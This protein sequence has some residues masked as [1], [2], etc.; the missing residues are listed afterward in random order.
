MIVAQLRE[1]PAGCDWMIERWKELDWALDLKG[2]WNDECRAAAFDLLGAPRGMREF[3][4]VLPAD[5]TVNEKRAIARGKIDDLTKY[6]VEVLDD[7]DLKD[8]ERA[9]EG[10]VWDDSPEARR[11][12][13]YDERNSRLFHK[14]LNHF[15]KRLTSPGNM[16]AEDDDDDDE[17]ERVRERKEASGHVGPAQ[18]FKVLIPAGLLP[19]ANGVF[20][21]VDPAL[22]GLSAEEL[23]EKIAPGTGTPALVD[24]IRRLMA[25][26]RQSA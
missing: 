15:L 17:I 4:I 24:W 5:A 2:D 9:A 10:V 1:T 21:E 22:A 12:R 13:S 7:L 18:A 11:F 8:Q 16:A 25:E 19:V 3:S 26:R 23:A 20:A 6:R 14:L